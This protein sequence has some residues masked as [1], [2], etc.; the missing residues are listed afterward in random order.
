MA[1]KAQKAQKKPRSAL[2]LVIVLLLAMVGWQL[3]DLQG[4]VAAAEVEKARY[5]SEVAALRQENDALAADIAEGATDEMMEEIA[6]RELDYV[7]PGEYVFSH[8]G[9]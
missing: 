6:R 7:T 9:N 2:M 8:Q 4:Q 5:A 1:K 3:Y